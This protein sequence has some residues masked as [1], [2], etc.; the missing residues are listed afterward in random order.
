METV[1]SMDYRMSAFVCRGVFID[2]LLSGYYLSVM[3]VRRISLRGHGPALHVCRLILLRLG[4]ALHCRRVF[5]QP[6]SG[7]H[8]RVCCSTMGQLHTTSLVFQSPTI[9]F[10]LHNS[11]PP[12][13]CLLSK[14][15]R[16]NGLMSTEADIRLDQC[17]I[18]A[19]GSRVDRISRCDNDE[20]QKP[21]DVSS[22]QV[23]GIRDINQ[24]RSL[25]ERNK[26]VPR[27]DGFH[28][29]TVFHLLHST[30][31]ILR[32]IRLDQLLER[33]TAILPR[34]NQLRNEFLRIA[35]PHIAAN[36]SP[37]RGNGVQDPY[38]DFCC[39]LSAQR[40]G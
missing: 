23:L 4:E 31:H 9:C 2:F 26:L 33:K 32:L 29:V 18:R 1:L 14:K 15:D 20:L 8:W 24:S 39:E 37:A 10:F 3:L 13:S 25:H 6:P 22:I 7:P 28:R 21:M 11:I 40:S 12:A 38:R 36:I 17:R 35:I 16:G 34:S 30:F 27:Y 19:G 5:H